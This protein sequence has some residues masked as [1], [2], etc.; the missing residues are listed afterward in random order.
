MFFAK[1]KCAVFAIPKKMDRPKIAQATTGKNMSL[2]IVAVII[3][4]NEH[5]F[6]VM[7]T[8]LKIG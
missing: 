4:V 2:S 7:I 3:C 6:K 8:V 1:L 5:T